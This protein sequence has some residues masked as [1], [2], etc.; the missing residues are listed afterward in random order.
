M[1]AHYLGIAWTVDSLNDLHRRDRANFKDDFVMLHEQTLDQ[2][3]AQL[4]PLFPKLLRR[5]ID[6]IAKREGAYWE[7]TQPVLYALC[8]AGALE[9]TIKN[10]E[11]RIAASAAY[12]I[13]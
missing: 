13:T 7:S 1:A 6:L 12:R 5:A 3:L 9:W 10:I 11:D 4:E 8:S 2:A